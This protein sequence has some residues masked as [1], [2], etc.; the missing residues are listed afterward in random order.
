VLL[1]RPPAPSYEIAPE[2]CGA[3][4]LGQLAS[5]ISDQST[6]DQIR[7]DKPG[8]ALPSAT[9]LVGKDVE[10]A[11]G[12]RV[13]I[14]E[15]GKNWDITKAKRGDSSHGAAGCVVEVR[16]GGKVLPSMKAEI[17]RFSAFD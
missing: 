16:D 15:E 7:R 13:I 14:T 11:E 3:R 10:A 5:T 2:V 8:T 1:R 17:A 4:G 12:L 9:M 6:L